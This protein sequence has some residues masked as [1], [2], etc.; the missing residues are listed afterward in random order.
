[1]PQWNKKEV[2]KLSKVFS[3][4]VKFPKDRWPEIQKAEEDTELFN[5]LKDEFLN[6]FWSK[7]GDKSIT[8]AAKGLF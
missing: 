7:K 3:M 1:M 6:T 2:A 8:E 4:Y 5:K